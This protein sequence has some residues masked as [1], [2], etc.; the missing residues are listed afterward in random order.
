MKGGCKLRGQ[1]NQCALRLYDQSLQVHHEVL[2]KMPMRLAKR[3]SHDKTRVWVDVE[4]AM[5][6]PCSKKQEEMAVEL[7]EVLELSIMRH[8]ALSK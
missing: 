4:D 5:A 1:Q 3:R 6:V 8:W 2:T 7:V